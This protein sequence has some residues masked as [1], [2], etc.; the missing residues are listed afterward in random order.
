MTMSRI[1]SV[2]AVLALLAAPAAAQQKSPEELMREGAARI[3]EALKGLL[4]SIPTY[5]A[6]EMLPNGDIIIRRLPPRDDKPADPKPQGDG[7]MRL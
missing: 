5:A 1:L 3:L 2:A 6:P 4:G 7:S